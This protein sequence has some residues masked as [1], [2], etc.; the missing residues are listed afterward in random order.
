MEYVVELSMDGGT[1]VADREYSIFESDVPLP[2][3]NPGDHVYVPSG[4]GPSG[5]RP[6]KL[7]VVHRLFMYKS[8][9]ERTPACAHVQ[10]FYEDAC[11]GE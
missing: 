2:V 8:A 4:G 3:P 6:Q 1:G 10:V 11:P 7:K 5:D 9:G